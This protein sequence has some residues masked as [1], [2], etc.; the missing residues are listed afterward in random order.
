ML[1]LKALPKALLVAAV[2]AGLGYVAYRHMPRP[3]PTTTQWTEAA[4]AP[5]SGQ[6]PEQM[7]AS[8][9]MPAPPP[10]ISNVTSGSAG[11]DAVLQAGKK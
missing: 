6:M 8:G 11:I 9:Q 3:D 5:A 1:K 10:G 2:I 7:P 4:P